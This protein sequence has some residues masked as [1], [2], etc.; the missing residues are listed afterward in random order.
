M[1]QCSSRVMHFSCYLHLHLRCKG[2]FPSEKRRDAIAMYSPYICLYFS[3]FWLILSA[4]LITDWKKP[5]RP[6]CTL[7][8]ASFPCLALQRPSI[9]SAATL[10]QR[11]LFQTPPCKNGG[12]FQITNAWL[13]LVITKL[14][15]RSRISY[16]SKKWI[17]ARQIFFMSND[18]TENCKDFN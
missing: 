17:S 18:T 5:L 3:G 6:S 16:G 10:P 12:R 8:T 2:F 9:T 1:L 7:Q 14:I 13:L 11:L 4:S 15:S